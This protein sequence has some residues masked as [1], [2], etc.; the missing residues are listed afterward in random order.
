MINT[1]LVDLDGVLYQGDKLIPGADKAVTWLR[2][3]NIPH[4]FLTNTTSHSR[5]AI[6][7]KLATLGIQ[8]NIDSILTPVI[9]TG[10]WL[11]HNIR[12]PVALFM[13]ETTRSDLGVVDE[14]PPGKEFGAAAV[15][16]GDLGEN[17]HYASLNRAFRL[18]MDEPTPMLI[19]LGM[20]RYWRAPDGLRLDVAPFVKALEHATGCE[21]VVFG[22][23]SGDFFQAALSRLGADAGITLMIGD[24]IVGDI[25]GAQQAG[26]KAALVRTGKFRPS[27]LKSDITPSVVLDSIADL[28]DWWGRRRS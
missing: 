15:I 10:E 21:A 19:A 7:D 14:L 1:V 25:R 26:L 8:V 4:L 18:L 6:A 13:P 27:D 17:W 11:K 9:A 5:Q 3:E 24:D 22:K 2:T 23:P 20:T 16:L 28:P 12:G